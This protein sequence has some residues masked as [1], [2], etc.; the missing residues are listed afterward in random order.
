MKEK[1][2]KE[3]KEISEAAKSQVLNEHFA[4]TFKSQEEKDFWKNLVL[5]YD[6]DDFP[7]QNCI[8]RAD[9]MILALRDREK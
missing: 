2:K 7:P 9:L 5:S 4:L 6:I 8:N 3:K 1:E